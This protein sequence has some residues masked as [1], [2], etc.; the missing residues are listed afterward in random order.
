MNSEDLLAYQLDK[1]Y[2]SL[3]SSAGNVTGSIMENLADKVGNLIIDR[4]VK[5]SGDQFY[6]AFFND[7][8]VKRMAARG[9][10]KPKTSRELHVWI[11]TLIDDIKT[12]TANFENATAKTKMCYKDIM[13]GAKIALARD[14]MNAAAQAYVN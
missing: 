13:A 14:A 2:T 9:I 7:K 5:R 4:I 1:S 6:N 10:Q 8:V 11:R 12:E 3:V